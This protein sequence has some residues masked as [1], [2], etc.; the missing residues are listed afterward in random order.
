MSKIKAGWGGLAGGK[1][2]IDTLVDEV[3]ELRAKHESPLPRSVLRGL[4]Q[5]EMVNVA[6]Y[7][8]VC[9]RDKLQLYRGCLRFVPN[10]RHRLSLRRRWIPSPERFALRRLPTK[11][12]RR[13]TETESK[14]KKI[15]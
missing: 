10:P 4:S 1:S 12:N 13:E 15:I 11:A 6:T 2:V 3:K 5:E 14:S 9:G 7:R 8:A